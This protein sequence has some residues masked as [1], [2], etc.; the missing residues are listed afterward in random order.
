M[1]PLNSYCLFFNKHCL[2]IWS[3]VKTF[4]LRVKV[5]AR[6]LMSFETQELTRGT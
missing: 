3:L 5:A 4:S 2:A 1:P 6:E